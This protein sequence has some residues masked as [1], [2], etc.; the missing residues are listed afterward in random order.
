T[1]MASPCPAKPCENSCIEKGF[2]GPGRLTR[3]RKEIRIDKNTSIERLWKWPKD[4][5]IA[6]VFHKDQND[7]AQAI[8]RFVDYIHERPKEVLQRLGC[9]V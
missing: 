8:A 1:I 9:A 2:R 7:I 3:W 5:V 4:T 6:N